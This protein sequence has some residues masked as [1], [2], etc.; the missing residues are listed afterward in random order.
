MNKINK[1]KKFEKKLKW[2]SEK[3]VISFF[4]GEKFERCFHVEGMTRETRTFFVS[5]YIKKMFLSKEKVPLC[6]CV[7]LYGYHSEVASTFQAG[8]VKFS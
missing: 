8:I 6:D 7:Y 4:L 2:N 3:K 5:D 1:K